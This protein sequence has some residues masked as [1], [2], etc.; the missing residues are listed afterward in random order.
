M[1]GTV[2]ASDA[3][4]KGAGVSATTC[5]SDRGD[6]LSDQAGRVPFHKS[7]EDFVLVAVF[8]GIGGARAAWDALGLSTAVYFSIEIDKAAVRV[9]SAAWPDAVHLG[10]VTKLTKDCFQPLM[11]KAGRATR[12]I[13]IGG[14]PCQGMSG[15]NARRKGGSG[16]RGLNWSGR[17]SGCT[18]LCRPGSSGSTKPHGALIVFRRRWVIQICRYQWKSCPRWTDW[19]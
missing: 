19:Q 4:E 1:S 14:F 16:M 2:T 6:H 12:G 17:W 9:V 18:V 8:D 15:L 11:D 3:S 13:V 5:L 7:E 10:D